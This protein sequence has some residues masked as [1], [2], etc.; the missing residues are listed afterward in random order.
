MYGRA[1]CIPHVDRSNA[2]QSWNT[3]R[4]KTRIKADS[5]YPYRLRHRLTMCL[6]TLRARYLNT[7]DVVLEKYALVPGQTCHHIG[8]G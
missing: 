7:L 8:A 1:S 6:E 2:L 3:F 5:T 4:D